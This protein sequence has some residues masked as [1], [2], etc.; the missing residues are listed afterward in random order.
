MKIAFF[1]DINDNHNQKW[2]SVLAEKHQ[3]FI[4]T[5]SNNDLRKT[6]FIVNNNIKVFSILPP[7]Y[8]V[9]NIFIKHFVI[10]KINKLI[11][12]NKIEVKHS[13]YSV[14][15]SFWAYD[16]KIN[17]HIITTYGSDMLIDYD[18]KL[19][20]P[21]KIKHIITY[22]L[23]CKRF[24]K[25][26]DKANYITSTSQEQQNIIKAFIKDKS[27][28]SIVRTGVDA[29]LFTDTTASKTKEK[30]NFEIV[31]SNRAMRPLYNIHIIVDAFYEYV[32]N[33][34]AKCKAVLILLNYNT[35]NDYYNSI[36]NKIAEYDIKD[37]V[38][39]LDSVDF[40]TMIQQY[41]NCSV[42]VMI[43]SSDGTPV[44]GVETL[45][46]K[47]PLILGSLNYDSD[48]FN[49]STVWQVDSI[50]KKKLANKIKEV[51]EL[52]EEAVRLKTNAGFDAAYRNANLWNEI[53][54]I[55]NYYDLVVKKQHGI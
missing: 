30:N 47:K 18:K 21:K 22:T 49:S 38:I 28:L 15:Y 29:K 16:T 40:D 17:N 13:I 27:K 44:S 26:F 50:D 46:S 24:K 37:R 55:E 51:L 54:K 11:E 8:S 3:L 53:N 1:A 42:V 12:E 43:P 14:P 2:F 34:G 31:L 19:K 5:E 10:K 33:A 6:N 4:F 52:P 7:T 41:V 48:L 36:N 45:L 39:I 20:Q 32:K 23:L 35:D 25:I 9:K